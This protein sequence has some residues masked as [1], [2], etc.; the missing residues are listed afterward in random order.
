[1]IPH[2]VRLEQQKSASL[3]NEIKRLSGPEGNPAPKTF[4]PLGKKLD[5]AKIISAALKAEIVDEFD[6]MPLDRK[7]T[8][9]A[10]SKPDLLIACCFDEDPYTSSA[11][12]VLRE[13][14]EKAAAGLELA[15][16]ACGAKEMLIAAASQREL[17]RLAGKNIKISAVSAGKRY[18]ARTLLLQKLCRNGKKA[19]YLGIQSCAALADAVNEGKP[20][21]ETVVTVAGDGV[22]RW[23][24]CRVPIGTPVE[25]VLKAAQPEDSIR[26]VVI[27]S[28][29]TGRTVRD[30][31]L[32]VTA[33]TRCVIALKKAP[34]EQS[35]PCVRC[36]RCM[37][38]CPVGVIPWLV[39]REMESGEPDPLLLFHVNECVDCQA[40]G[41]VCPSGIDLAAEVKRAAALKEGG[42]AE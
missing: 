8:H 36:G 3:K 1:M 11:Q 15:A 12:A 2:G 33:A 13:D 23:M 27:G 22:R 4:A 39:Y 10:E 7:L 14:A 34:S 6:G 29:V 41:L 26:L 17:H 5:S 21:S 28:S 16:K 38:A 37:R 18:P 31:T 42:D 24:N 35:Y 20:Q 25:T 30:L 9:L 19:A 40:C 32:P